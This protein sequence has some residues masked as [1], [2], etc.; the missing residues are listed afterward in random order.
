VES[1]RRPNP[2]GPVKTL[3]ALDASGPIVGD[4]LHDRDPDELDVPPPSKEV[5]EQGGGRARILAPAHA[6]GDPLA[7]LQV[8][9]RV[10]LALRTSL[11]ELDE[12]AAAEMFGAGPNPLDRRGSA[13]VAPHGP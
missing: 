5:R 9:L 2:E 4:A 10:Q 8:D 13:A 1:D 3:R 11:D 7:P 12:M 6:D